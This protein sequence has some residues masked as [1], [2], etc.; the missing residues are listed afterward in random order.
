MKATIKEAE[1][2][3]KNLTVKM[4]G[5][6]HW[7]IECDYRS[8]RISTVTTN[9]I[10]V[11]DWNSEQGETARS[12]KGKGRGYNRNLMGYLSLCTEIINAN[13]NY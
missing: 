8:K 12:Y 4:T 11:D 6:G 1:N 7:R 3:E 13:N 2:N 5:Y 10:A 9:S